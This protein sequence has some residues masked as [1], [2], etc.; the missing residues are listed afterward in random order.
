MGTEDCK[1]F[2]LV[3]GSPAGR[4]AQNL[5]LQPLLQGC[6]SLRGELSVFVTQR[7]GGTHRRRSQVDTYTERV[8]PSAWD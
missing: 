4:W 3:K 8:L 1:Q 5:T 7:F 2:G 6:D